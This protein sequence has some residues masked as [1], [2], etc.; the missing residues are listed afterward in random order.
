VDRRLQ[1][2]RVA[3]Q[4]A[5]FQCRRVN[6]NAAGLVL[7]PAEDRDPQF[8]PNWLPAQ[9]QVFVLVSC[10][11]ACGL[12]GRESVSLRFSHAASCFA[13]IPERFHL[14]VVTTATSC[15][16]CLITASPFP[17]LR[18]Q[19]VERT[20]S[21]RLDDTPEASGLLVS[22]FPPVPPCGYSHT[23]CGLSTFGN[24]AAGTVRAPLP[25]VPSQ[26]HSE[27]DAWEIAQGTEQGPSVQ[28]D[29]RRARQEMSALVFV[30]ARTRLRTVSQRNA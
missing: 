30:P 13:S 14:S 25:H 29:S 11:P 23:C 10:R 20:E 15:S 19:Q 8:D 2:P 18:V 4:L 16:H 5:A 22:W 21:L 9:A 3:T 1:S 17:L 6:V 24:V 27:C 26:R 28:A 12:A 7:W